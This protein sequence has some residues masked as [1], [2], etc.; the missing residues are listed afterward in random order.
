MARH[1]LLGKDAPP[2]SLPGIDGE[3]YTVTPG[4]KGVPIALFFYPEAGSLGCTKEACLFRDTLAGGLEQAYGRTRAENDLFKRT[5]VDVVGISPDP[6]GKQKAFAEKQKLTY[7]VLSDTQ[8]EARKAYHV[9]K[10]MYGLLPSARVTFFI[11]SKG[12]VRDVQEGAINYSA[13]V[14]LVNKWLERLEAEE[15]KAGE[16]AA[17]PTEETPALPTEAAPPA[18]A[19][20]PE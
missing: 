14:K 9:G 4:A 16:G 1:P 19:A 2:V 17:G 20:P 3:I 18:E 13:H 10:G 8:G 6:V 15:K 12:V 7:P 5:K 11:D